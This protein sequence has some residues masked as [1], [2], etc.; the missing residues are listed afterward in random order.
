MPRKLKAPDFVRCESTF[1]RGKNV[2][3]YF[4]YYGKRRK[5][6]TK[7][8][9]DAHILLSKLG[10]DVSLARKLGGRKGAGEIPG[11]GHCW[12]MKNEALACHPSQVAKFN[13]RNKKHGIN[14]EYTRNGTAIIPD[15]A[16][17]NRLLKAEGCHLNNSYGRC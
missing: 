15:R 9:F 5:K 3:R 10:L 13:E 6:I 11:A 14:V 2:R 7:K 16:A 1:I 17:Y 12:P 4:A 8:H